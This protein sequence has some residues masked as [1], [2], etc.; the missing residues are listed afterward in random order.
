MAIVLFVTILSGC[1]GSEDSAPSFGVSSFSVVQDGSKL[2]VQYTTFGNVSGASLY[3]V[4]PTGEEIPLAT[5]SNPSSISIES[6]NLQV[7]E[8][9]TL[10]L[11]AVS[12]DTLSAPS[13]AVSIII[14]AYCNEPSNLRTEIGYLFWDSTIPEGAASYQVQYGTQG[15]SL[16]SGSIFTV[17]T[18][19]TNNLTFQAGQYYD[20]YVRSF[21]SNAQEFSDWVGPHTYFSQSNQNVCTAP[22]N[23][24]YSVVD[25]FFGEP[26][27]AEFTWTDVG[28]SDNYEYNLVVNGQ[29][30]NASAIEQGTSPTITYLSL[31]QNTEYDFYVRTRCIDGTYTAWVGPLNVNIGN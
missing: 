27:G 10:L 9:V 15:F 28:N 1:S 16:G 4:S 13:N 24:G 2:N 12:D 3:S 14:Q 31:V 18:P 19:Y 20:L 22:T 11:Y 26:V 29:S 25:N 21:C 7:G 17:N 5:L 23:V 8:T 6:L 30:P